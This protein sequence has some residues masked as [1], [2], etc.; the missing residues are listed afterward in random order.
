MRE[1]PRATKLARE[2][3]T[4]PNE[5]LLEDHDIVE[6]KEP[7]QVMTL[8]KRKPTWARELIQYGEK[9]S[10]PQGTMRQ[11]KKPNP[12]SS[13]MTLMCDLLKEEPTFFEEAIQRKEWVDSMT[14]EYQSIMKNEVWEIV[15]RPKN[16]YV[17]SSGWLFKI[18]H[19][20]DGSIEKYKERFFAHG[21][22]HKKA[23]TMKRHSFLWPYTLRSEPS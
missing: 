8:H 15:P 10:A 20:A 3:I 21:F 14:E 19:V 9:Y 6:V 4:S 7:P 22:S 16:K 18:E 17:V 11:V 12:F 13:Y 5:K 1:V 23:L 2:V